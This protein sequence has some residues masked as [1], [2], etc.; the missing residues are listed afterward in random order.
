MY[1]NL[2][3]AGAAAGIWFVGVLGVVHRGACDCSI[4]KAGVSAGKEW[5]DSK[6]DKVKPSDDQSEVQQHTF[7][8]CCHAGRAGLGRGCNVIRQTRRLSHILGIIPMMG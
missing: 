5:Q 4:R 2:Q 7:G 8:P 3:V 6:H 1:H